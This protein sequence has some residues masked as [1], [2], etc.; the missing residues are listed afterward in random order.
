MTS[1]TISYLETVQ[2]FLVTKGTEVG[3]GLI[4]AILIW[5]VGKQVIKL[6]DKAF[7]AIIQKNKVDI[8]LQL[9]LK[10]I[11]HNALTVLL[12]M[13]VLTTLG[14]EMTSFFALLGAA[15]LAVGMA[16]QGSLSNFAGGVLILLLKPF[17]VGDNIE[18]KGVSGTVAEIQIFHTVLKTSNLKTV[19][20]PNGA[21]YNDVIINNSVE[22]SRKIDWIFNINY[23]DN[24]DL[25]RKII[26]EVIFNDDRVLNRTTP[27]IVVSSVSN[28]IVSL[29]ATALVNT[30]ILS[31]LETEKIEAVKKAFDQNKIAQPSSY[32]TVHV[33]Q[34]AS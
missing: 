30:T 24:I 26:E 2:Q 29:K 28:N 5:F 14:I 18:A 4:K 19:I 3:I 7:S 10:S 13:T 27:S 16:L 34:K 25:A 6:I 22:S 9:F 12:I 33:Y 20:I 31:A 8:S 15:G 17:K 23:G 21:L 11:I 32:T 1:E